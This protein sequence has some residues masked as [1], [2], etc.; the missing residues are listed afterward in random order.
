VNEYDEHRWSE[1]QRALDAQILADFESLEASPDVVAASV[2]LL[3]RVLSA[4]ASLTHKGRAEH[5]RSELARIG[6]ELPKPADSAT[7]P[8]TTLPPV[9]PM[10]APDLSRASG[11]QVKPPTGGKK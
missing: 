1:A 6:A 9:T 5:W 11:A 4:V 2:E 7:G 3:P 10:G 8:E